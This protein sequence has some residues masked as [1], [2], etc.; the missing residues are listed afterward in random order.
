M[1]RE[2]QYDEVFDAQKHFRTLLDSM[3]RPGKINILPDMGLQPPSGIHHASV[4]AGFA[5]LNSDVSFSV[6]GSGREDITRYLVIN[7]SSRPSETAEADFVFINGLI[8]P[9]QLP[10]LKMGTLPYPENSATLIIDTEELSEHPLTD[11]VALVLKGPGVAGEKK[12][13]IRGLNPVIPAWLKEQNEEFPLG[14]DAILTDGNNRV[15]CLPRTT[16]PL[17]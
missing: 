3:A 4:L 9:E 2:I 5:L 1:Q 17:G 12:I 10:E 14:I 8:N 11:A 7:T 13:Y 15:L 16:D 6:E